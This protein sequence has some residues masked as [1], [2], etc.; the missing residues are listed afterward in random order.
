MAVNSITLAKVWDRFKA[1]PNATGQR[2]YCHCGAKYMTRYGML[3]ELYKNGVA[4]YCLAEL[5]PQTLYDARALGLAQKYAKATSPQELYDRL[6]A[7]SPL[8]SSLFDPVI[9]HPGSWKVRDWPL[10]EATGRLDWHQLYNI[11]SVQE[12]RKAQEEKKTAA[13]CGSASGASTPG[14]LAHVAARACRRM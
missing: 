11:P 12:L 14:P 5:P 9:G 10:L 13:Q 8:S 6:P 7:I 3:C 2:W 4:Y 1:D